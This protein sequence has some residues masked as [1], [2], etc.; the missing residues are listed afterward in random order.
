MI[1]STA[2]AVAGTVASGV[3]W[4]LGQA[5]VR[6]AA[7]E[8]VLDQW[9]G[10][11]HEW[12][13]KRACEG[14]REVVERGRDFG[15]LARWASSASPA[16]VAA[17]VAALWMAVVT[18]LLVGRWYVVWLRREGHSPARSRGLAWCRFGIE[19]LTNTILVALFGIQA[20]GIFVVGRRIGAGE[21]QAAVAAL[22]MVIVTKFLF[23]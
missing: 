7:E 1:V 20:T 17:A 21:Y 16:T 3:G 2:V 5:W 15:G 18:V 12:F 23:L 8:V 13:G 14:A 19:A 6:S 4:W 11:C 10:H 22:T 9:S